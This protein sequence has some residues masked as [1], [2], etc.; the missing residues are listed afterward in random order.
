MDS[1]VEKYFKKR[2]WGV[3]ES[4]FGCR[5]VYLI[6]CSIDCINLCRHHLGVSVKKWK[7]RQVTTVKLGI[8]VIFAVD[9]LACVSQSALIASDERCYKSAK[10]CYKGEDFFFLSFKER[11]IFFRSIGYQ[12]W[13]VPSKHFPR[14]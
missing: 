10:C 13:K 11:Y 9:F 7:L 3:R 2:S 14:I 5:F 6:A 12:S 4:V 1:A 8:S